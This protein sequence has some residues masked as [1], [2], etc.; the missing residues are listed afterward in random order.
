MLEQRQRVALMHAARRGIRAIDG[1][2]G[3]IKDE[4]PNAF[5]T[6]NTLRTRVFFH[7]PADHTPCRRFIDEGSA[8]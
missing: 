3:V 5:H 2:I 8:Y 1:A 6:T 4:N 7:K